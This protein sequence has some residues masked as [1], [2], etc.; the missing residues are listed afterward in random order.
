MNTDIRTDAYDPLAA[1]GPSCGYCCRC[2]DC[3][4]GECTCCLCFGCRCPT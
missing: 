3:D 2:A 1:N 4:C